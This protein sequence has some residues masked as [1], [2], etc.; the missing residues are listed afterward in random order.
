MSTKSERGGEPASRSAGPHSRFRFTTQLAT[1]Q[2]KVVAQLAVGAVMQ[3]NVFQGGVTY[4]LQVVYRGQAAGRLLG[5]MTLRL[6]EFLLGGHSF[7]ATV[8]A[9][10]GALVTV[11]VEPV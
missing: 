4:L 7:Q 11:R 1:P 9:I 10:N 5:S 3:V 2:P 8:L 6:R